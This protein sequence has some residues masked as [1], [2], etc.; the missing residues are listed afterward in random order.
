MVIAY[1]C[2]SDVPGRAETHSLVKNYFVECDTSHV[3]TVV[4]VGLAVGG[5]AKYKVAQL[6]DVV[7]Q[8]KLVC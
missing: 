2:Y 1:S 5:S 4:A 3:R 7:Q 6:S 8:A